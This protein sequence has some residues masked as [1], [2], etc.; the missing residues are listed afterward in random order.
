MGRGRQ[1]E[2]RP[3]HPVRGSALRKVGDT[4]TIALFT[5][6]RHRPVPVCQPTEQARGQVGGRGR[7]RVRGESECQFMESHNGFMD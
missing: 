2:P 6:D 5:P 4:V 7:E 1:H 3:L